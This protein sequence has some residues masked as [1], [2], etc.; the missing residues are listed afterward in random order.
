MITNTPS[1][2]TTII[3]DSHDVD[4]SLSFKFPNL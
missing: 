1:Y 2:Y 3:Q 4:D